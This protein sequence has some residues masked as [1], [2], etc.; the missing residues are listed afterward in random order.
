LLEEQ[1]AALS[2][3]CDT[4]ERLMPQVVELGGYVPSFSRSIVEARLALLQ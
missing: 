3:L 1:I 4:M 2:E